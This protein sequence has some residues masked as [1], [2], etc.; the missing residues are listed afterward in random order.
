[1]VQTLRSVLGERILC[2][3]S[4]LVDFSL[5]DVALSDLFLQLTTTLHDGASRVIRPDSCEDLWI[6]YLLWEQGGR[7][8]FSSPQCFDA[9]EETDCS[10]IARFMSSV[11]LAPT[12]KR[13]SVVLRIAVVEGRVFS[14]NTST[15]WG[16]VPRLSNRF[17]SNS[18]T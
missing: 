17:H 3:G 13:E 7:H 2:A 6:R 11:A 1:M 9:R 8:M 10:Q 4:V 5:G 14:F 15:I 18:I 16:T 12:P